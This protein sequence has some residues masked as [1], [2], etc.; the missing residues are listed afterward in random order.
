MNNVHQTNPLSNLLHDESTSIN[1]SK[2]F[3]KPKTANHSPRGY[4]IDTYNETPV[5]N[6]LMPGS[7]MFGPTS[8]TLSQNKK[9]RLKPA[10]HYTVI[11]DFK[12][13]SLEFK[14]NN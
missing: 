5:E 13:L 14:S 11:N 4:T 9:R 6:N 7:Q 12:N 2:V 1:L 3:K 8:D 10:R